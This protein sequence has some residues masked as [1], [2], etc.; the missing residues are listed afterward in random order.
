MNRKKLFKNPNVTLVGKGYKRKD[1]QLVLDKNGKPIEATVVGVAEKIPMDKLNK[2]EVIPKKIRKGFLGLKS[3]PTDVIQTGV[4]KA[5][6]TLPPRDTKA[7]P[8]YQ[9]KIRPICAGISVGHKDITAGTSGPVVTAWP[10]KASKIGPTCKE[11]FSIIG[12]LRCLIRW[13]LGK[14]ENP[15]PTDPPEDPGPTQKII[16]F[17]TNNHVGANSTIDGVGAKIGDPVLQQGPYD[18]GTLKEICGKLHTIIPLYSNMKNLA[19]ACFVEATVDIIGSVFGLNCFPKEIV[20]K[21]EIKLGMEVV[22]QGRTTGTRYGYIDMIEVEVPVWYDNYLIRFKK[23]IVIKSKDG[24]SFSDGGDSGSAIL[25]LL[26]RVVALLFAGGD[27]DTIGNPMYMVE[28][29]FRAY[30]LQIQLGID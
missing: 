14:E 9:K 27:T 23:Q 22:K 17:V 6:P 29:E 4:I 13:I 28:S 8:D 5:L 7:I 26:G 3:E 25:D 20:P 24:T 12:W 16:G 21:A 18:G 19:D 10:V 11:P 15:G 2:C 1:G 30:G